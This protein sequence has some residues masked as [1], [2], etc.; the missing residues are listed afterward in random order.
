MKVLIADKFE[1]IGLAR[2]REMGCD[3]LYKPGTNGPALT[4]AL[5]ETGARVLVVR[6]TRVTGDMLRVA[7]NLKLVIRA[8]SGTDTID[9]AAATECD[10]RVCNC[11]GLN[12]VAVAELTIGLMIA[13][14]R[15]IAEET[16]DLRRGVWNKKEYSR[17]RGLKGRTLGII[18]LG[19]I[20]YEVASRAKAFEMR[21]IYH[22]VVARPDI[23]RELGVR[24]V[25]L[26]QLLRESDFITLH[27]TGGKENHHLID[28]EAIKMMKPTAY[29][30]NCSRGD[31]LD[32]R[33][34]IEA[35]EGGRIAG[36]ALDVYEIE[37]A[38]TDS[39]FKDPVGSAPHFCG[40]H[41]VGASTEQA[42]LAIAEEV[43]HIVERF[44][45]RSEALHCVNA[46]QPADVL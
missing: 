26:E 24:P 28:A 6:S 14:D 40:T 25:P 34:L 3:V 30:L 17:A 43:A 36:A 38:A 23:E 16:S 37:P 2:L 13:L 35:L 1:E 29:L 12:S 9:V 45:E 42:Q 46:R 11:P 8:G 18:G 20:G 39:E 41:H 19:R 10:I 5:R 44:M 32:E 15:R 7:E 27:V 22:D 21:L 4:T 31:V 33:A